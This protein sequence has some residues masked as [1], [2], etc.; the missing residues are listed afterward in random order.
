MKS[1]KSVTLASQGLSRIKPLNQTA[2]FVIL[3]PTSPILVRLAAKNV[4][5]APNQRD[6]EQFYSF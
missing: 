1:V 5:K 3:A 6:Y 2:S 4:P